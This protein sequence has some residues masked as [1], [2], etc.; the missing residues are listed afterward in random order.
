M[1]YSLFYETP[2]R[3]MPGLT[4]GAITRTAA[5]TTTMKSKA[6]PTVNRKKGQKLKSPFGALRT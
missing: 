4:R 5:V 3:E 2:D 1:I 6:G